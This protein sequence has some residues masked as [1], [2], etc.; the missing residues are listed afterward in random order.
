MFEQGKMDKIFPFFRFYEKRAWK[1][2][3]KILTLKKAIAR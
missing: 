1:K 2:F 3:G